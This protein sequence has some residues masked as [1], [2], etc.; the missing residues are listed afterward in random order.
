MSEIVLSKGKK[1]GQLDAGGGHPVQ[2]EGTRERHLDRDTNQRHDNDV[3][4]HFPHHGRPTIL[5]GVKHVQ[6]VDRTSHDRQNA[7]WVRRT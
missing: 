2:V 3:F 7:V 5:L 1:D 6:H 4:A